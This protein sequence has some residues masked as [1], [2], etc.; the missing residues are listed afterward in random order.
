MNEFDL[1]MKNPYWKETYNNAT[2]NVKK[3]YKIEWENNS[4]DYTNEIENEISKIMQG[5]S[6]SDW[7][8]LISQSHGRAKYEYTKMMNEKFPNNKN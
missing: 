7:E 3:L 4:K 6:K 8:L 1:F 2:E 5:F